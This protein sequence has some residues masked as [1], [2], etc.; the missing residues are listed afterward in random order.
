MNPERWHRIGEI[1]HSALPLLPP[2]RSD[3]VAGVCGGD[4]RLKQEVNLLLE[5]DESSG[6]FL[7]TAVF[8]LGLRILMDN[9]LKSSDGVSAQDLP[10]A[11]TLIGTTLDERYLIERKLGQGGVGA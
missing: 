7:E 4:E 3:F 2:E 11:D 6:S 10:G 1:Y 5:A 8:E 9:N